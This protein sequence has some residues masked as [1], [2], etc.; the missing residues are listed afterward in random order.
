MMQQNI[1]I[2]R[3]S[4]DFAH[5]RCI[6]QSTKCCLLTLVVH[7]TLLHIGL[8]VCNGKKSICLKPLIACF[9][10]PPS[11][12]HLLRL[13]SKKVRTTSKLKCCIRYILAQTS[14]TI[15]PTC[16]WLRGQN[17]YRVWQANIHDRFTW[18]S[19]ETYSQP[20][21]LFCSRAW[22]TFQNV[23]PVSTKPNKELLIMFALT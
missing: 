10:L 20:A 4:R 12:F 15:A 14:H 2:T 16:N 1:H 6:I 9:F 5:L 19:F 22:N 21:D 3:T 8:V 13:L 17:V 7:F 23:C 11:A 18:A